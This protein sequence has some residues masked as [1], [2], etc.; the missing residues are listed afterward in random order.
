MAGDPRIKAVIDAEGLSG[1]DAAVL[2]ALRALTVD[3]WVQLNS[4]AVFEALDPTE[5]QGLTTADRARV[6]RSRAR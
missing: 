5:F 4:A 1:T 2:A 3:N 6:W